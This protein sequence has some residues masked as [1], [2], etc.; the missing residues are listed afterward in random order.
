MKNL[1]FRVKSGL[2]LILTFTTFSLGK[3]YLIKILTTSP[4]I[5]TQLFESGLEVIMEM[6]NF[7][8]VIAS[9]EEMKKLKPYHYQILDEEPK[10]KE[11]FLIRPIDPKDLKLVWSLV[12]PLAFDGDYWLIPMPKEIEQQIQNLRIERTRLFLRPMKQS[13]GIKYYPK[14]LQNPLIEDMVGRVNEDS[15]V[16]FVRRLQNFRTRYSTTDSCIAAANWVKNKFIAYGCDSVYLEYYRTGYAPNVIGIKRGIA[17]PDNIYVVIC[18]HLD[19]TSNQA[20][21]FCPGADDNASG[22]AAV[23]EAA[24]VM[25][26]YNF[27][28]SIRYIAFTGEEQGLYGSEAYAS[29][30]RNRGDSIF[31]VINYDMIGYAD[32]SPEDLEVIGKTA[33]PNCQAFVDYF[34]N[35]ANL[36]TNLATN[37]RMVASMPNS[38]HHSFWQEGYVA[39]CGIEDYWPNNPHYHRTS[40]TI[41]AGFNAP[42]FFTE[43]TKA[44][45][46]CLASLA[47]PIMPNEPYITYHRYIL[48]DSTVGNN[49]GRWDAGEEIY[50]YTVLRNLGN[51]R[52]TNVTATLSSSDTLVNI[53]QGYATFGDIGPLDSAVNSTPY[54]LLS[55]N[56]TPRGH[57]ANFAL[58]IQSAESSWIYH[59]SI[60][61]APFMTTDPIPDGPREPPLYWA[62]DNTDTNYSSDPVYQWIE[63]N[64]IGTRLS[65]IHNDQVKLVDLPASFGPLRYYGNRYT[66]ISIS[67]DGW[68]AAGCDTIRYYRN[69]SIP[70]AEGPAGFIALNFD[71]LYPNNSGSGG[72]YYYHDILNHRF[73]IEYDSV[74]YYEPRSVV[75][76]FELIIYDTTIASFSGDNILVTQYQTA[77]RYSSSTIGIEDPSETIGIQ[78]LCNGIYHP[79]AANLTSGRAIKYS[80]DL[81][82][83]GNVEPRF[84][85]TYNKSRFRLEILPNPFVDKAT[86]NFTPATKGNNTLKVFNSLGRVIFSAQLPVGNSTLVWEGRDSRGERVIPGI[87]F[88]Q[89]RDGIQTVTKKAILIK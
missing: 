50:L 61:I 46:A 84:S 55:F 25:K 10:T 42:E 75:D 2:L 89:W 18:G 81:P 39:F 86:V 82:I 76:K 6:R 13:A 66:Q 14:P 83:T 3:E 9:D 74:P 47:N 63:I 35:C 68:I 56:T 7:L 43:V 38:D 72:V 17:H 62:Y 52:A 79:G 70:S 60:T 53:L 36:Y 40:D 32:T 31:G 80:T 34:V 44:G 67:A 23:L 21:D 33:N 78:Y 88:F 87:Y 16:G 22:T 59:F 15:A 51:V 5:R 54:Q 45:V 57:S 48:D 41:G 28:Y 73:I 77:N 64:T 30:A 20:P 29:T 19:A 37:V 11:Y 1:S 69:T 26:D 24:R 85:D 71:D 58:T 49:N 12:K 8:L 27:E 65:F 4:E